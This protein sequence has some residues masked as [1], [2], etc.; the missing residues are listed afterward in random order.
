MVVLIISH[1]GDLETMGTSEEVEEE[2]E[3]GELPMSLVLCRRKVPER[4][5]TKPHNSVAICDAFCESHSCK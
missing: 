3:E 2:E 1:L 5:V 4:M